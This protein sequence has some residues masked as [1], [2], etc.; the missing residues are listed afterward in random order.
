V[1]GEDQKA[2]F[3]FPDDT[4]SICTLYVYNLRVVCCVLE[5]DANPNS[6][7]LLHLGLEYRVR[8]I[9]VDLKSYG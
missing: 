9:R 8:D 4:V 5:L 1:I 7:C 6:I 2:I 3:S